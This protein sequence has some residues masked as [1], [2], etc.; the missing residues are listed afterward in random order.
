MTNDTI[1]EELLT[2]LTELKNEREYR[3]NKF[4]YNTDVDENLYL[5]ADYREANGRLALLVDIIDKYFGGIL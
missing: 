2:L 3:W 1:K 4:V 5:Y